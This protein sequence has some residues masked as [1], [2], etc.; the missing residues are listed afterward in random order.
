MRR[1]LAGNRLWRGE[2]KRAEDFGG[3]D[4]GERRT[5]N[6]NPI[7]HFW[8]VSKP[9]RRATARFSTPK[10]APINTSWEKIS[11]SVLTLNSI[12][13]ELK[14][15]FWLENPPKLTKQSIIAF[16]SHNHTTND[17]IQL[18]DA[19]EGLIKRYRLYEY[20]KG[21]KRDLEGSPKIKSLFKAGN[22]MTN[23]EE[24]SC[25]EKGESKVNLHHIVAI[26]RGEFQENVPS[27]GTTK[28]KIVE[29]MVIL[30]KDKSTYAKTLDRPKSDSKITRKLEES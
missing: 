20:T 7:R 15:L 18:K 11:K 9:I 14:T 2:L 8:R 25:E 3:A 13:P 23:R 12:R 26:T 6:P 10:Y 22:V 29:L 5:Q 28:T 16:K 17:F 1:A 30:K 4:F 27:K 19:I 21:D 24:A